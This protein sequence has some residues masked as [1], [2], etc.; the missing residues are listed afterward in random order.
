MYHVTLKYSG[1]DHLIGVY[2][3]SDLASLAQ[4]HIY[5]TVDQSKNQLQTPC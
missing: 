1:F 4:L 3:V 2:K 5:N